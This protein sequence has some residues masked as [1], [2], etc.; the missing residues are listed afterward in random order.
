MYTLISSLI[1]MD[2]TKKWM[3]K[4]SAIDTSRDLV[5][6]NHVTIKS[7]SCD[8]TSDSLFLWCHKRALRDDEIRF[9]DQEDVRHPS[10]VCI[11][12][13]FSLYVDLSTDFDLW[14]RNSDQMHAF[15]MLSL[16]IDHWVVLSSSRSWNVHYHKFNDESVGGDFKAKSRNELD[17]N[18]RMWI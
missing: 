9:L 17:W 7:W 12:Q 1:T 10:P 4:K 6:F 16:H 11:S 8:S 15:P 5:I 18:F 3:C 13:Y 2:L 14:E